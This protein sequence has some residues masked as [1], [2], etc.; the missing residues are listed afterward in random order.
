[1]CSKSKYFCYKSHNFEIIQMILTPSKSRLNRE[2]G[3]SG[4][5]AP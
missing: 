4:A 2:L 1:M 3:S 5:G